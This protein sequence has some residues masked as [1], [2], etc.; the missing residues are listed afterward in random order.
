MLVVF[1]D[2]DSK[3]D[4]GICVVNLDHMSGIA[5]CKSEPHQIYFKG[6]GLDSF[7]CSTIDNAENV[8]DSMLDAYEQGKKVF[9]INKEEMKM[10]G[11]IEIQI[12][13]DLT[14]MPQRIASA[15][16]AIETSGLVGASYKPLVYCG[17]QQVRGTNHWFIAEQTLVTATPEKH[18]V[19]LAVNE[20]NGEYELVNKSIERIF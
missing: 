2:T 4:D 1:R 7:S 16:A 15:A 5:I 3:G 9:R 13:T 6:Y 12:L 18:I 17:S 11:Q 8:L 19:K 10:F 14:K 20:F